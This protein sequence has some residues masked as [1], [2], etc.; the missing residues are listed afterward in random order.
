MVC[1]VLEALRGG[2]VELMTAPTIA[3][4]GTLRRWFRLLD[5]MILVAATAVGCAGMRWLD[6]ESA[7]RVSWLGTRVAWFR[8][9]AYIEEDWSEGAYYI[10]EDALPL[11]LEVSYLTV[12]H[13][14]MWTLALIPIQWLGQREQLRRRLC[15]PGMAAS[16]ASCV[17]L[18]FIGPRF[19][20]SMRTFDWRTSEPLLREVPIGIGLAVLATWMAL[21][22]GRRWLPEPS[23]VD[24]LS[25]AIGVFWIVTGFAGLVL[26]RYVMS[27]HLPDWCD[28]G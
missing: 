15:R 22:I 7:G 4:N 3:E 27:A 18:C 5:A 10:E 25:R 6:R 17:A 2:A 13:V 24:R 9:C 20:F 28:L 19:V 14:L 8:F 26:Y 16:W 23:W 11:I 21:L 12:P 1:A